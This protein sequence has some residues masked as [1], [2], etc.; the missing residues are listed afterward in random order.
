MKI[1]EYYST[2]TKEHAIV[3]DDDGDRLTSFDKAFDYIKNKILPSEIQYNSP[4][5]DSG[6]GYFVKDNIKVKIIC[7]NWVGT[8]IRI[9]DNT[10]SEFEFN[11]VQQWAKE[12]Y[13]EIHKDAPAP[14]HL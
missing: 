9:P 13:K 2:T 3:L 6:S 4:F 11:K 10:L 14:P 8:E 7:S 12:I 1:K 5:F